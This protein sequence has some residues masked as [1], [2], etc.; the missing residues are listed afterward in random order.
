MLVTAPLATNAHMSM[1]EPVPWGKPDTFPLEPDGSNFPCKSEPYTIN[2][3]NDWP[4]GSVQNLTFAGTAVHGGGSCQ[5]SVSTD[6]APSKTSKWKVIYSIEGG[7]P[8]AP[9]NG[10]NYVEGTKPFLGFT[11]TIPKELP[12]G[13][14]AMAWTWFNKVGNREMYMNCA[15]VKVSGGSSDTAAFDALPDMAV[16]NIAPSTCAT[17]ETFDYTFENPGKYSIKNG[18]G[19]YKSL[20][21]GAPSSPGDAPSAPGA[22]QQSASPGVPSKAP[23][24][25]GSPSQVAGA[26]TPSSAAVSSPAGSPDT[27]TMR[28]IITVTAPSGPVPPDATPKAPVASSQAPAAPLPSGS[29]CSPD[30][31]VVCSADG[32]QFALCNFGRAVFQPVA[33]GTSCQGGKIAR[34]DEYATTLKIVYG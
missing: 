19:P 21:G 9:S 4:V 8:P 34:R 24:N 33:Q 26:L 29:S 25:P 20:C 13:D 32:K 22:S 1:S 15:P 2:K 10:G 17:K 28:I 31:A 11:F 12:N 30:G 3:V 18:A 6:K 5:I 16:A 23:A 27:S 14:L 7:C